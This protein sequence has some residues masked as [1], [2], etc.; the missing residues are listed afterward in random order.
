MSTPAGI[1]TVTG[2]GT[3][4]GYPSF[5][6]GRVNSQMSSSN[7]EI[8]SSFHYGNLVCGSNG[9][10]RMNGNTLNALTKYIEPGTMVYTLPQQEGSK[11]VLKDGNL[12]FVADNPYG[13]EGNYWDDYNV[14]VNKT[15]QP[16]KIE[17]NKN[18]S[19]NS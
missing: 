18:Y 6:R 16:L 7:D 8:A 5:T 3:Y 13:E 9:C 11:F 14:T 4:H 10:V 19:P 12:S 17:L 2:T 1:T 15:Y